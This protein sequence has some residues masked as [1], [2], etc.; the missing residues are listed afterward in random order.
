MKTT[1]I[2]GLLIILGMVMFVIG[3]SL[4]SL[5]DDDTL[6]EL[7]YFGNPIKHITYAVKKGCKPVVVFD[8]KISII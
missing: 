4:F 5:K 1:K 8:I 3:V 2:G 7:P 6:K